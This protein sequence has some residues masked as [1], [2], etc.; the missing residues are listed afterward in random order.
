MY[1]VQSRETICAYRLY[2]MVQLNVILV[3]VCVCNPYAP[4]PVT[5]PKY[6]LDVWH[7]AKNLRKALEEVRY[8]YMY[9]C[10][11]TE[12][13]SCFTCRPAEEKEWAS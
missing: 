8:M 13:Y 12:Y 10:I 7:K 5:T 6:S 1:L 9:M 4:Q 11:V 3:C 2:I